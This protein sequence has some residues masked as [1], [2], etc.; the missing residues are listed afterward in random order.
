MRTQQA[1][2]LGVSFNAILL[3]AVFIGILPVI[4]IFQAAV[5]P[6]QALYTT[7]WSLIPDQFTIENFRYMF[8]E[9]PLLAWLGNSLKVAVLT[10]IFSLTIATSAGYAFSRWEFVGRKSGLVLFLAL[11]AFPGVLS[12]VPIFLILSG[13]GLYNNHWGLILAYTAGTLVFCTWNMKGYFD[14]VPKDLEEAAM[15]DGCNPTSAFLRVILPLVQPAL[16]VTALFAFLGGWNEFVMANVIMTGENLWTLP[17]G[18]YALQDNYRVPWGY[19]AAGSLINAVPV[20]L[21]FLGLQR[22][23]VSGLTVGGVKG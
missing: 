8:T 6:G 11:Q 9:R 10:T 7:N 19:F 23:L 3:V 20:M 15:I 12:L 2:I 16:A 4:F 17:V 1:R 14:T 5:R 13:L 21:L 22:Y 18:L